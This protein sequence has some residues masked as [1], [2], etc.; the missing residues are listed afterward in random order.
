ME[1]I[2]HNFIKMVRFFGW[3]F[4]N[5]FGSFCGFPALLFLSFLFILGTPITKF[6]TALHSS[7]INGSTPFI[8][9]TALER[10]KH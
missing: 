6:Q 4:P 8:Q 10:P 2:N 7:L 1:K 5:Y 3:F 9:G